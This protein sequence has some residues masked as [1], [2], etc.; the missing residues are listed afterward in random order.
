VGALPFVGLEAGRE[1]LRRFLAGVDPIEVMQQ[2]V[3]EL[4]VGAIPG[5][6]EVSI[7]MVTEGKPSTPTYVGDR[8]LALDHVQYEEGDGPCL[9]AIRHRGVDLV[10][11]AADDR[12][13]TRFCEV[14]RELGIAAA[15]SAPLIDGEVAKGALN[16][17][18]EGGFGSDAPEMASLVADQL[19]VAAVNA[20][21]Y[22]RSAEV[23]EQL[24]AAMESRAVIEQ[25][26]GMIM[27]VLQCG[28]DE[29]FGLL[30]QQS[31]HE[32]QKLRDIA[33]ELVERVARQSPHRSG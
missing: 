27:Q 23:A 11:L 22:V 17:Y 31:Q 8:A 3:L 1:A 28:P 7:T 5:V 32:N 29:A 10:S 15:L 24:R 4:A 6:D 2:Q 9:A 13:W 33:R 14:G 26:K 21:L 20:T 30:R 25:A 18:S 16:L 12:G 19:G